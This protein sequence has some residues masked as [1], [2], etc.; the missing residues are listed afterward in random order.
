MDVGTKLSVDVN[1]K[2]A[3]LIGFDPPFE[4]ISGADNLYQN[5]NSTDLASTV[6]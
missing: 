4:L 6:R 5:L 1:L 3:E 2:A